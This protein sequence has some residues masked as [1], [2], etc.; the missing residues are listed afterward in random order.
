MIEYYRKAI[1]DIILKQTSKSYKFKRRLHYNYVSVENKTRREV[2][3]SRNIMSREQR[4][5]VDRPASFQTCQFIYFIQTEVFDSLYHE[6]A[7]LLHAGKTLTFAKL[8]NIF[9]PG[10]SKSKLLIIFHW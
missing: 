10:S 4:T 7:A 8:N 6:P 2:S 3:Q 5:S 1:P 9:V